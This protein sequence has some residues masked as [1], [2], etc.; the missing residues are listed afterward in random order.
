[1]A[2]EPVASVSRML[3]FWTQAQCPCLS[4]HGFEYKNRFGGLETHRHYCSH[5]FE[6]MLLPKEDPIKPRASI[7]I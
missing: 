5:P 4:G 7:H 1:M 2:F 6:L 3:V